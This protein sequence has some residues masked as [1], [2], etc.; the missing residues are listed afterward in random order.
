MLPITLSFSFLFILCSFTLLLTF[1]PSCTCT[2]HSLRAAE[3]TL[4]SNSH[5][6][7][8]LADEAYSPKRAS[9]QEFVME[10]MNMNGARKLQMQVYP[11]HKP[12]LSPVAMAEQLAPEK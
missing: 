12:A 4:Y 7:R 8:Q 3:G 9:K 1:S 5:Q 10:N 11:H 6:E 2:P